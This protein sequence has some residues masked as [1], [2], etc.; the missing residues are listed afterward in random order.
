MFSNI[1][2]CVPSEVS[3][4]ATWIWFLFLGKTKK[5]KT[6]KQ[7]SKNTKQQQQQKLHKNAEVI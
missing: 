2:R 6:N 1:L 5:T 3:D 4:C 7:T